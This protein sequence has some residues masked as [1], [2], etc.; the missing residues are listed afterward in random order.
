MGTYNGEA[1]LLKLDASGEKQWTKTFGKGFANSVV[2]TEDGGYVFGGNSTLHDLVKTDGNGNVQWERNLREKA[3]ELLI[4]SIIRTKDGGYAIAGYTSESVP[5]SWS[6]SVFTL[7]MTGIVTKTNAEGNLLWNRTYGME[8]PHGPLGWLSCLAQTSD[9][10]YILSSTERIAKLN[11]DGS[12][13]WT[14]DTSG[15][16]YFVIPAS[17]GYVLSAARNLNLNEVPGIASLLVKTDLQGNWK[18]EKTIVDGNYSILYSGAPTSDNGYVAAGIFAVERY[19]EQ[20]ENG[21]SKLSMPRNQASGVVK[22]DGNGNIIGKITY[23]PQF[24]N[25][26]SYIGSIIECSDGDYVFAGG[27]AGADGIP[28]VWLVKTSIEANPDATPPTII[29]LSPKNTSYHGNVYLTFSINEPASRI[30]YTLDGGAEIAVSENS[31]LSGLPNGAHYIV[32]RAEDVAGNSATSETVHFTV[33]SSISPSPSQ[34]LSSQGL[35]IL[36]IGNQQTFNTPNIP[37]TFTI[38]TSASWI[39]YSLDG[40]ANVT[41]IGNATIPAV[42]EGSHTLMVYANDTQGIWFSSETIGFTVNSQDYDG[43]VSLGNLPTVAVVV[44]VIAV[45]VIAA[46]AYVLVK[47]RRNL[48]S[49][50]HGANSKEAQNR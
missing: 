4:S 7:N 12:R 21:T 48:K 8:F 43:K 26:S 9:D 5:S 16:T 40:Q 34:S 24:Q 14:R 10:G 11:P 6:P 38:D 27:F 19:M 36:S 44:A 30:T 33:D 20:F 3:G 49:S 37:L 47:L 18:W 35:S 31:T 46:V 15:I 28:H 42:S 2:Q 41:V 22:V 17:D 25:G 50:K 29:I 23:T 45:I 39:G 13:Q 1:M 32:V